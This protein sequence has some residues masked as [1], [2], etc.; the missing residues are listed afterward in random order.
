MSPQNR[1]ANESQ[2]GGGRP[3]RLSPSDWK[4]NTAAFREA[5]RVW[6]A[7][8]E[9]KPLDLAD[10]RGASSTNAATWRDWQDAARFYERT[11][12]NPSTGVGLM[13]SKLAFSGKGLLCLDFDDALGPD[14]LP[15]PWAQP[16]LKPFVGK[17]Y[18]ERSLGGRGVHVFLIGDFPEGVVR[19][20]ATVKFEDR[21]APKAKLEIFREPHFVTLSGD[22]LFGSS[23]LASA[24]EALAE[25]LEESGLFMKLLAPRAEPGEAAAGPVDLDE[26]PRAVEALSAIDPDVERQVWLECGMALQQA[27]GGKGWDPWVEW[28]AGGRKFNAGDSAKVWRSFEATDGGVT[29]GT[30]YHH[31]KEAGWAPTAPPRASAAED[32]AEFKEETLPPDVE[33]ER[34]RK[35]GEYPVGG[36]QDWKRIGLHVYVGGSAKKPELKLSEGDA[37]VGQYLL[38]HPRWEGKLRLNLRTQKVE[39]G[40]GL[41]I[42]PPEIGKEILWFCGWRKSPTEEVVKRAVKAIG[43]RKGYDPVVDW[44]AG[45]TWDGTSRLD[46]LC[47]TLGLEDDHYTR[48]ALRRWMIGAVARAMEP[49][50]EMQT[51]LVLHGGQGKMKSTFF[52]RLAVRAEWYSESH[53]DMSSKEGQ[54]MLLGPWIVEVAE[55]NGMSRAEV[56]KVKGFISERASRF[57]LPYADEVQTFDRRVVLAG[58]TNETEFLR[59]GTGA[60]RFWLIG[61]PE[62]LKLDYLTA[63]VVGQLWAEARHLYEKGERWWDVGGEVIEASSRNEEHYQGTGLDELVATVLREE[64]GMGTTSS[65]VLTKLVRDRAVPVNTRRADV[66]AAIKRA[67]W[68]PTKLRPEGR[69]GPQTA[70]FRR[71]DVPSPGSSLEAREGLLRALR[72]TTPAAEF[73]EAE[74]PPDSESA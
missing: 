17:T 8:R 19:N 21:E 70:I 4:A 29:L 14:G 15:R 44:L 74:A 55:L 32:F 48:R 73:T 13:L 30:L 2:V 7:H 45:L 46:G 12:K 69:N 57:R 11:Q 43:L 59:D 23:G 9:K 71:P 28:S 64:K 67:G 72:A 10:E 66:G 65:A 5:G 40:E 39:H 41:R 31:A 24:P 49:G 25:V 56:E 53:V 16:L 60:R 3:R 35:S 27:F 37:N 26:L 68:L 52:K 18:V 34:F 36:P 54:M 61:V 33:Q 62:V 63:E 47:A 50:C 1:R 20:Q 38:R 42:D 6:V 22:V 51:M 58:T